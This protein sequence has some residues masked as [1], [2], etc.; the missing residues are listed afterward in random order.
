VS[1]TKPRLEDRQVSFEV[2]KSMVDCKYFPTSALT[3]LV[4]RQEEHPVGRNLGVGLSVVT[5]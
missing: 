3:L 5:I 1:L 4:E 2:S